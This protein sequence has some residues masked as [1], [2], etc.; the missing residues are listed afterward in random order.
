MLFYFIQMKKLELL[1]QKLSVETTEQLLDISEQ[2]QEQCPFVDK[3]I[4]SLNNG[5][6]EIESLA[7][8]LSRIEGAESI[9]SDIDWQSSYYLDL[10]KEMENIRKQIIAIRTW[11]QEWKDLSK[12]ILEK[13]SEEEVFHY[14]SN[15]CQ[16]KFDE[17][18]TVSFLK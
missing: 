3:I 4:N 17:L 10:N 6:K 2:P 14:M 11:G 15:D 9:A 7:K 18:M 12:S 1:K 8:D 5:R 16:V 13:M